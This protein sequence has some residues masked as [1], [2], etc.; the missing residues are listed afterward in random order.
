MKSGYLTPSRTGHN[1]AQYLHIKS[2]GLCQGP[3]SV[4][5]RLQLGFLAG[6]HPAEHLLPRPPVPKV[7]LQPL[8]ARRE[9]RVNSGGLGRACATAI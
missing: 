9:T 7:G 3:Q 1:E 8:Q 5:N 6:D 2:G 4:S